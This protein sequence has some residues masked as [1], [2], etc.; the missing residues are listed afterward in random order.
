MDNRTESFY[1][2]ENHSHNVCLRGQVKHIKQAPEQYPMYLKFVVEE[3]HRNNKKDFCV[4]YKKD[5]IKI[6]RFLE[7]VRTDTWF[8]HLK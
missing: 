8:Y 6:I 3:G 1:G 4:L 2:P 7:L 5:M